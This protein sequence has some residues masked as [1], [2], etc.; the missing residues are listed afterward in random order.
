MPKKDSGFSRMM[1]SGIFIP[2]VADSLKF[3]NPTVGSAITWMFTQRNFELT[4][5]NRE[6]R[7]LPMVMERIIATLWY[8]VNMLGSDDDLSRMAGK[9]SPGIHGDA[10]LITS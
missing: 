9:L 3:N 10:Q 7:K 4:E 6:K 1:I 2:P 5:R 8:T